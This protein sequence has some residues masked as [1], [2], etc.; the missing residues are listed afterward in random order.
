[1]ANVE[2]T[3]LKVQYEKEASERDIANQL[4]H[5]LARAQPA[6]V[7]FLLTRASERIAKL[8]EELAAIKVDYTASVTTQG[9][10]AIKMDKMKEHFKACTENKNEQLRVVCSLPSA[11]WHLSSIHSSLTDAR[12]YQRAL[13]EELRH[14]IP[15]RPEHGNRRRVPQLGHDEGR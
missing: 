12:G 1:M 4:L 7:V 5:Q 10:A 8:E 11:I 13:A 9:Q 14:G 3:E 15:S 2:L 6:A